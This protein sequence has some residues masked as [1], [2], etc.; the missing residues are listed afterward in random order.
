LTCCKY[1][2]GAFVANLISALAGALSLVPDKTNIHAAE[3]EPLPE[4]LVQ[5]A[6]KEIDRRGSLDVYMPSFHNVVTVACLQVSY[7]IY[8]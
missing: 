5:E 8:N 3:A 1:S 4:E 6:I 7:H 2:D